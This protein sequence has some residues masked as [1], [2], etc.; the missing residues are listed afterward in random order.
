MRLTLRILFLLLGWT[1]V[2]PNQKAW[3]QSVCAT[4]GKDGTVFTT[5]PNT[6]YPGV[7][8]A[9]VNATSIGVG[10]IRTGTGASA[11]PIS[12]GDLLL[13]IQM[14]GADINSSNTDAYGDGVTGGAASG[15]S[16]INLTAGQYEYVVAASAISGGS[17]TISTGLKNAYVTSAG[18]TTA[19]L[20][21]LQVVRVPQYSNLALAANIVPPFWDGGTGG[22]IALDVQGQ[23]NFGTAV[24]NASGLGFRGGAG[25]KQA[26]NAT[27]T[28]RV[29]YLNTAAS[30]INAQK[31]EG[32]AGSP[33]Y[34]N[35]LNNAGS[36]VYTF[37]NTTID[38]YP[39]GS[40]GRGA[41]GNAGGGANDNGNNSGGGGGAN[42][43]TGGHGGY[44]SITSTPSATNATG[45]TTSYIGG[46]PGAAFTASS[47]R[48]M[49]GGG[50]G[51][52][53][54][55]DGSGGSNGFL[56]S[57]APGGGIVLVRTGTVGG[58][59]G[60]VADGG[61]VPNGVLN[62]G[63]G[64]GGAGGSI[65]LTVTGSQT[66]LSGLTLSATGGSG[67]TVNPGTAGGSAHGPGGGGGGGVVF[68]TSATATPLATSTGGGNNGTTT[69]AGT[70]T[71]YVQA[72]FGA[73]A[74]TSGSGQSSIS[75]SNTIANSSSGAVCSPII[76]TVPTVCANAGKDGAT[77]TPTP[78]SYY[79]GSG[80]AAINAT[81]LTVGAI[82]TGT[83]ASATTIGVGDLLLVIQMQG[84]DIN[85]S[86]SASYGI[87]SNLTAGQYEYVVVSG[88][89]GSTITLSTGLKNTYVT[90][91]GSTTA[92]LRTFQVVRVPQYSSLTLTGNIVPAAWNGSTGGIVALD[93]AGAINLNG[94]TINVSGLGFRGGAGRVL[95]TA[96]FD[97]VA[98]L[99]TVASGLNGQKG[100]GLAG[101]PQLINNGGVLLNT[102]VDG[103][104]GGSS[105][106]GAPGNAG[107]GG[108]D[109]L[110]NSGGGGGANGGPGGRGGK[111]FLDNQAIGGEPGAAFAATGTSLV[112]GGGGGAGSTNDGSG[113]NAGLASSGSAGGGIVIVR[114]GSVAG[115]GTVLANA[116]ATL[117]GVL[118]DGGGGGGAGGSILITAV[119]PSGL[120]GLTLSA[121]GAAGGNTNPSLASPAQS[122]HGPGGGGGGGSIFTNGAVASAT[123]NGGAS[124]T[125]TYTANGTTA[126]ETYGAALGTNGQISTNATTGA[127]NGAGVV[128]GANCT[129]ITGTIFDD[130]NYGG[131]SGRSLSTA[132]SSASASGLSSIGSV[133]TT[134]ELYSSTGALVATTTTTAGGAYSFAGLTA[135]AGYT[136]RVVNG[137]VKSGRTPGATGL[138]PVQTFRTTSYTG[139]GIGAAADDV[140][141]VGGEAPEKQDAAAN[142]G[143]Q[144]LAALTAG[145]ATPQSITT[146][147]AGTSGV[148][149]GYN[150]DVVVNTNNAGQG[151]LRQFIT[152]ANALGNEN[153]LAQAGS[154]TNAVNLAAGNTA[155]GR[156]G[157]ALPAGLESSI[158]MIP[159]ARL[160]NGVAVITPATALPQITGPSTAINGSTQTFN[161]GN[162]NDVLLGAGG[163]VGTGSTALN[164]LNGPE[165]QLVGS[166]AVAT[167]L[168]IAGA[169]SRVT[170]LAIYGFGN[171]VDDNGNANI[172]TSANNVVITANALGS[173]ATSFAAPAVANVSADVRV[174]SGTGLSF[175]NN[176]VG[177][178]GG[179]GI[180]LA[181]AVTGTTITGNEIRGNGRLN[182]IFDGIDSHGSSTTATGNL[183]ADSGAQGFDSF[184]SAGSNV[185]TGNTFTNNGTGNATSAPVET[186][187]ARFYGTGNT[188]SQNVSTGNYG[189]G[190]EVVSGT[191]LIS[192]NSIFNNGNVAS[193]NGTAA[194]G[195]IGIDLLAT[196]S[197]ENLGN[198]PFVT[199]NSATTTGGNGLLNYPIL[200]SVTIVGTNLVVTGY[201]KPG[202]TIELFTAQ[203]NPAA[204]NA[205]G[206]NFGQGRTYLT[207]LTEGVNDNDATTGQSYS[208]TINGFNQGSDTNANG[209]SFTIPLSSLPGGTL[210]A[211]SLLTSTATIGNSTSE[212]SGNA[213]AVV[214][215]GYVYEDVNYGGGAG[216]PRTATGTSGRPGARVELYDSNG[217]FV[218]ATTTDA[219]GQ[220]GFGAAAGSYTVRVVN[221]SV[222]S[223]RPGYVAGLLPVQ[224]YNGTTSRVGGEAPAK[225]D[226]G[227]NTTN[228]TL[229]SL[230]TTTN[231]AE[232]QAAVTIGTSL[233]TGPDFGF[234]FDVVTNTNS[235][236]QGSLR[237]FILNSNALGGETAL[238]QSGSSAAGTL[239]AGQE[240]SIF[241]IPNGATTGVP[242]GLTAFNATTNPG[243]ASQLTSG[244]A[245]ITPATAL[246]AITGPNTSVDGSTQTFN[247]GD[248]NNNPLG[249][250]GIVGT[251]TTVLS[252]V[253]GPEVQLVGSTAVATGLSVAAAGTGTRLVGLAIYGFGNN[254]DSDTNG[255]IVSSANNLSVTRSV[256]GSSATSFT[257]PAIPNTGSNIRLVAGTG[258]S[259][260]NNLV[261]FSVNSGIYIAQGISGA[262][263]TNNEIRGNARVATNF[264]GLDARGSNLTVTGNLLAANGGEGY[265][266]F[267]SA[268]SNTL[269]NN[270]FTGNG[271]GNATSAPLE[272]AGLRIYGTGNT[273][274][275]NSINANYGAGVQVQNGATVTI[276]QNAI[277]SNGTIASANNTAAT[278]QIGIDLTNTN[279]D[280]GTA[281][282]VTLNDNADTDTG[283]NGFINFPILQTVVVG[284]NGVVTVT[285]FARPN[286]LVELFLAA[287][288][289][290]HFGEGSTYLTSF[291]QGSAAGTVGS[292]ATGAATAYSGVLNNGL[293]QGADNTNTF[294]YTFTPTAAQLTLL[295]TSGAL[296]TST[297]TLTTAD[298]NGNV[299]TSEFS[300]NAR[301]QQAPVPNDV[302]NASVANN[303][304]TPV[305][306]SPNLSA[307]AVGSTAN[308]TTN[309]ANTIAS[310]V[311][312]PIASAQGTLFYNGTAVTT[313]TTVPVANLGQLT[314]VP[315]RGFVGNATFTYTANDANGTASTTHNTA[316]TVTNGPATYTIPVAAA[317]DMTA[318]LSGGTTLS[319]GQPTGYYTATFT[320]LGPNVA[321]GVVQAVALPTGA[322]LS[323]TQRSDI[324]ALYP[325]A[326]FATTG[327]GTT[328]M[329]TITFAGG[330]NALTMNSGTATSYRFAFTAPTTAG[331]ST[332]AASTSTTS[333]EGANVAANS[334]NLALTTTPVV[335]VQA[336]IVATTA[337]VAP[338]ATATFTATFTNNSAP[339]AAG[340]VPTVQLIPGLTTTTLTVGGQTGTLS[341]T[342]I[343][344]AGV[345][346]YSTT[347]GL[348]TYTNTTTLAT[349]SVSSAIAFTMP[350]NGVV[351]ATAGL[352]T[353]TTESN[354]TNNVQSA[355]ITAGPQFD[356]A[357][358]LSSPTDVVAGAPVTLNVTTTNNSGQAIAGAVQ[359]VQ[360]PGGLNPA[361]G[362]AGVFISNGGTYDNGT[363]L[364]TFP[365][366]GSL[367]SGQTVANTITFLAPS[368]A[369]TPSAQVTPSTT[370][371]GDTNPAN[372]TGYLNGAASSTAPGATLTPATTTNPATNL[373]ATLTTTST[374]VGAGTQVTY[375]V[376]ATNA[377]PGAAASTTGRL[378]LLPGLDATT[379][380]VNGVA[381][382]QQPGGV[383]FA[384]GT[385]Y[386]SV[387]YNSQ[388]GL[389][390]YAATATSLASGAGFSF[391]VAVTVPATVGNE[392]QLLAT[393]SV[394][395]T[396]PESVPADNVKA[397]TVTVR[398]TA[399]LVATLTGPTSGVV[400]G[401]SVTYTAT[402]TNNGPD[403]ARVVSETVQLP[404]NLSASTLTVGGQTGTISGTTITFASGATYSTT[405][406]IVTLPALAS[407]AASAVQTFGLTFVAP[408][409]SYVVS[410]AIGSATTDATPANNAAS[411]A[412]AVTPTADVA[413]ALSGP[414]T[415]VIG[416]YATYTLTTTN[417]GPATATNVAPTLQLPAGLT[418]QAAG[419][420]TGYSYNSTSGL[421]TFAPLSTLQAGVSAESYVTFTMPNATGG[422]LSALASVSSGSLDNVVANNTA[423]VTT[424]VAPAT[425][426][427]D[428]FTNIAPTSSGY[429][430]GS[431]IVYTA[432]YKNQGPNAALNAVP[433]ASLPT[434]LSA[435][436]LLVGGVT[437]TLNNGLITFGSG[438]A[439]GATYEVA[440]GLLTFPTIANMA[441]GTN[442]SYSISFPAPASGQ[443]LV[444]S[445]LNSSTTDSDPTNNSGSSSIAV[446]ST[447]DLTTS[448]SGPAAALAGSQNVYTITTT[449]NGPSNATLV[450]QTVK[451]PAAL[452][453]STLL[454]AGQTGTLSGSTISFSNTGASYD[455]GTGTL[456]FAVLNNLASGLTNSVSNTITV[457]MPA[458]GSLTVGNATVGTSAIG[459]TNTNNNTATFTT[460][461]NNVTNTLSFAPVAQNI[462][463]SLR[464]PEGNTANALAI[465][466][467]NATDADGSISNYSLQSLPASGTLYY[468]G[469]T[470]SSIPSGG[471]T[472]AN[473]A[474]LSY[475]PAAGYV[476]NVS[477]TYTATDNNGV[478]SNTA[479]Y[480]IPVAQDLASAYTAYN[481][482]KGGAN[483]YK[484]ND[485]L[486]Q[487]IDPNKAVYTSA[488]TI[489]DGTGTLQAG[490]ANGLLTTGTNAVLAATGP[491]GNTANT[492]PAG[493]SLDPATGRIYVSDA[494]QLVN[495]AT[496]RT[497]SVLVNTTDANGGIT[498]ALA[499]FTIGAYPLP[500]VLTDFTAQA[501]RNRDAFLTWATASEKN[502]HHFDVERSFDGASFAKIG[503]VAGHGTTTVASSYSLTDANVAAKA[504]GPVYYRLRQVDLDGTSSFSPVR[505][506]R[507]TAEAAAPLTLSLYPNP[508]QAT[509][510]LD[511]RQLPAS[512]SYQVLLLDATGRT[513]RTATLAGGLPQPL[514]VQQ[515]AS[516]TYHVRV[517]G[518]LPDGTSFKQT[519]RLTKE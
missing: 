301:V 119:T 265:D 207:T 256:I 336:T 192:R 326:T 306:L 151:S 417:N 517:T 100:E 424:S 120:S 139:T 78:N 193:A 383:T 115:T 399:D 232:S 330:A 415:A 392:G 405:T 348:I 208:G 349:G 239:P 156:S 331:G 238:A 469:V 25:I 240:T 374:I 189:A 515:L 386:K 237:Q 202:A 172:A 298:A 300:G 26:N 299:G 254:G 70:G 49:M 342:T 429:T 356:L 141:R 24:I 357:T 285:G 513:V 466:P 512:G 345:A 133:G 74:G 441:N 123:A 214:L 190:V 80:T 295:R 146:I 291:T 153:L 215:T 257:N 412:T 223:S 518:Q 272:T 474:L 163:S 347:T 221:A 29:D 81:T 414:A 269:T 161:I 426:T 511:L 437:G 60:I 370:G 87:T 204:V 182:T 304:T 313:A 262:T 195:Q 19:T 324:T 142:S 508:A 509:T 376:G 290:T 201:A 352:T 317:A 316:G 371:A 55:N 16:T 377:G 47:S 149:F 173:T 36:N 136:V 447:F 482:A 286:T 108:N 391:P 200:R 497:Y 248:S 61:N 187:A 198:T 216:R 506:V 500:V 85:T 105:A 359:T 308:V 175:T 152:N 318:S 260:A 289:P 116:T 481:T 329:T 353:T 155:A 385:T 99:T 408:A 381:G 48:L 350:A 8:T 167:G 490:A 459:E 217:N 284:A 170:G 446:T 177:F 236:G 268:G 504:N 131:G 302:T 309:T 361:T 130:S 499:T 103:Y 63:G 229:A 124:G 498:Q 89:S 22:I 362:S 477:F 222:T 114:A 379:L 337:T 458:T 188:F 464:S 1:A 271:V 445:A 501:V 367:P 320:N 84:A 14:Q 403:M 319:P 344:F 196:G 283:A 65:L 430:P 95:T 102:N 393:N 150:F 434:G 410:S 433:T 15:N 191:T 33:Q 212:F 442:L 460:N 354:L 242:A 52:G 360:L 101:T 332:L 452:T 71:G 39:G 280:T 66:G 73:T 461:V 416:N 181:P 44:S 27:S 287:D 64:G 338:G 169:G 457:T 274:S 213:P 364:V 277:F 402:F 179:S 186:A 127:G 45:A 10:A 225:E 401:Q 378:Q 418:I 12:I 450:T 58:S 121:N 485:I 30:A 449:N 419:T 231:I 145:T 321:N 46:E 281:P 252:T 38:N 462:V 4:P 323:T 171:N 148:N 465:S 164:Q 510:Q 455:T 77:F 244:V 292:V 425:A 92:T 28:N 143:S 454:V 234:N 431:T 422:Q 23:L 162:S 245:V 514:D 322:S 230:N 343:T 294:T 407:S 479:R 261:G 489:F 443:L 180:Y 42:G 314:F 227:A 90:A 9:A 94:N 264:D 137:T 93:V 491:A 438:P 228:A 435:T 305:V 185:V 409:Q 276:S 250:G 53:S 404:A 117:T 472:A 259:I 406:G 107:G 394:S 303:Q 43:G 467:L 395:S 275:Q 134:V 197:D 296:L 366:L 325:N 400:P 62:D 203:A 312:S 97:D 91:A 13:I 448:V 233:S 57:G 125:T 516:G 484:T 126:T 210:A 494:S 495:F 413:L 166:T 111:N 82:R 486:A 3:A 451:L 251:G 40:S 51:A 68:T 243:L 471:Y 67:G 128:S 129:S 122:Q 2:K 76:L 475:Q 363:G 106:R 34:V 110:N 372:N 384:D 310:Y 398:P 387:S 278:G 79:A 473:P 98:Y 253:N 373:V 266:S 328:A 396:N 436:T 6:Y 194:S 184:S 428:L 453:T 288:D 493:V 488:G 340:V 157:V 118:N 390:S 11:T 112:L 17:V 86:N 75:T 83:G 258:I 420:S 427:T 476:G 519:L 334:A 235:T 96:D 368:A 339:T 31:G 174:A 199:L 496:A 249:T 307:S 483:T 147:V 144:T 279:S 183:F 505:A 104:P 20:R 421:L 206:A 219:N 21:T 138:V 335:D 159:A 165:V 158:F 7:G 507:F 487:V 492:L 246:P 263:V 480:T 209:F 270:T 444:L 41:P 389:L 220:Y 439:N 88:V 113:G 297:A 502:N 468:N 470:I 388:T 267:G 205:T 315:A 154:S 311:V 273:V 503:T 211:G 224:T 369:F 54:T 411:V 463:N 397:A 18:S 226:A 109:N 327:S 282:F 456:T 135:G 132:T 176:L 168:N 218:T 32:I 5:S 241:M 365:A 358:S 293:N 140:N 72:A 382:T 440:T 341:G 355:N 56:S 333:S 432:D 380:L 478:V 178:A 247:I 69:P 59:G 351:T 255:N 160:T 346:T 423:A 50:G 375:T 37:L 35:Y